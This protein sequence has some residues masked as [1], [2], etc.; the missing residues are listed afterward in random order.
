M[1][2][3]PA[4]L[5][6]NLVYSDF[7]QKIRFAL[8]GVLNTVTA[9]LAFIAIYQ[10]SERY[11]IASVLSYFVGMMVSYALNRTFVF[12]SDKKGGQFLPFCIVN[13][14]SLACSTGTL[15]LLVHYG[16]VHV[17]VA[18]ALAVCVSMGINY[19]GYKK[20]FTDG[21]SMN[22]LIQGLYND[23]GRI[24]PLLV[25]QWLVLAVFAI[26]TALNLHLAMSANVAH[27][28]LP[29]M[30]GYGN[31]FTTE[32]RWINFAL[33]YPL[34][35][36][37]AV[38]AASLANIC[39]FIFA[40]KVVMGIKKEYWLAIA[41]AL[42]IVNIPTF[43]MLLKWPM[44][45]VPGCFM[46]ALF[47]CCKDKLNTSAMLIVAG[48]LLFATYPA[49]YFLMP[50]LYLSTLKQA[51]YG[52]IFKFL[53]FWILGYVLGYAVANSLVYLY[54]SMFTD[55]ATFIHFVSW[56]QQTPTNSLSSL[57]G[58]IAKSAT[59]FDRLFNYIGQISLWIY[60]PI[61][62]TALWALV[63]HF[64]YT[65]IIILV[66]I[67]LYASVVPLGVKVPL[68]SGVTFPI[69]MAMLLLLIP[70]KWWRLLTLLALFIPFAYQTHDYN[71]TYANTR[72]VM[73]EILER[74]DTHNY[75]QQPQLFDKVVVSVDRVKMSHYMF[76][77]THSGS[78][79]TLS[80][81]S[82]H[83]IKPYLYQY[84]WKKVNIDVLDVKRSEIKV[85]TTIK[86]DGRVLLVSID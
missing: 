21:V 68:R 63:K 19:L 8:V 14:T 84:G 47:A 80:N 35:G 66:V 72:N 1:L 42:L 70:N 31:K 16:N 39:I 5:L 6:T 55:H 9:Y 7:Q 57:I 61:T 69:G 11:L 28:A 26:V 73:A 82:S 37:S 2:K 18:Q 10:V 81:L 51:S 27:D 71:Y 13:L 56:R 22:R 15:Y 24:D 59:N 3:K 67:S 50:L 79:K 43:T 41:V 65:I 54:T 64:K 83:Y 36:L 46:L 44:T 76:E 33:Y 12:N 85:E 29:Y 32:G 17:Y 25:T 77:K 86:K 49:F 62:L 52:E 40:Y 4:Q 30:D 75:L 45:L 58:N 53:C 38:I 34:H 23:D 78:F 74:N 48:I 20:V 60:V